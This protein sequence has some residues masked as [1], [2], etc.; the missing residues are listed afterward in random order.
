MHLTPPQAC[1]TPTTLSIQ[2]KRSAVWRRVQPAG[3]RCM[4]RTGSASLLRCCYGTGPASLG[5]ALASRLRPGV[6]WVASARFLWGV[7]GCPP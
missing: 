5:G 7:C 2:V 6:V 4:W 1:A 3:R